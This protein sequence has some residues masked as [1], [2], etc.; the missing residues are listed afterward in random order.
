MSMGYITIERYDNVLHADLAKIRLEE[1]GIPVYLHNRNIVWVDPLLSNA[2]GSIKVQVPAEHVERA[3][4]L[5][6]SIR[7]NIRSSL[8]QQVPLDDDGCLNCGESMPEEED[9]CVQCGWSYAGDGEEP[10]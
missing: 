4:E 8:D 7:E 1:A 6:F 10:A 2:V 3:T 9:T 5:I